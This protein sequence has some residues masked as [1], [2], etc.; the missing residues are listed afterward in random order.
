MARK[1]SIEEWT[2]DAFVMS[3]RVIGRGLED[4]MLADVQRAARESGVG[5][6]RGLY[7]PTAKNA[8]VKDFY[9]AR[10]FT[11]GDAEGEWLF[12]VASQEATHCDEIRVLDR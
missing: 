7:I 1:D 12:D 4:V 5:R 2:I 11:A 10:G 8:P 9:S 6:L 3:C